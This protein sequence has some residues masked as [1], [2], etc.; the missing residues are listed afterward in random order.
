MKYIKKVISPFFYLIG[1]KNQPF[2]TSYKV[3]LQWHSLLFMIFMAYSY[4][5]RRSFLWSSW[6]IMT[7]VT[8]SYDLRG[9]FLWSSWLIMTFVT[10]SYDLHGLF[11]WS[12]G[13]IL[14]SL[15]HNLWM[16][17]CITTKDKNTINERAFNC[18]HK[19]WSIQVDSNPYFWG[20]L[21][22]LPM[23]EVRR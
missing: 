17:F 8:Y 22:Y 21:R 10:Y 19:L 4:D 14:K 16:Y 23:D 1:K 13:I 3:F 6:L 15:F 9:L 12:S 7:F 11:L 5:L 18:L 20:K 2:H